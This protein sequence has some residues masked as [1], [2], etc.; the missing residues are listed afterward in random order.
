M[1]SGQEVT[2]YIVSQAERKAL[3][4]HLMKSNLKSKSK[5]KPSRLLQYLG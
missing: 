3:K 4:E 5:Q 2:I 1:A